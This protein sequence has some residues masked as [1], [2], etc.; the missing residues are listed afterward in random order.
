MITHHR[1]VSA[2]VLLTLAASSALARTRVA[3]PDFSSDD[4]SCRSMI[5]GAQ[6]AAALQAQMTDIADAEWVERAE[7]RHILSEVNLSSSALAAAD[8]IRAGRLLKADLIIQGQFMTVGKERQLCLEAI[9]LF[10]AEVMATRTIPC[11]GSIIDPVDVSPEWL[12]SAGAAARE[13]LAE[14]MK[15][16]NHLSKQKSIGGLFIRNLSPNSRLNFLNKEIL[17]RLENT[18][19]QN[20]DLRWLKFSRTSESLAEAQLS[21]MGLTSPDPAAWR[22]PADLFLWGSVEEQSGYTGPAEK[23]PF[24]ITLETWNGTDNLQKVTCKTTLADWPVDIQKAAQQLQE[25]ARNAR[26]GI[27]PGTRAALSQKLLN[28]GSSGPYGVALIELARFFSPDDAAIQKQ[29]LTLRSNLSPDNTRLYA[30]RLAQVQDLAA[31]IEQY[32]QRAPDGKDDPWAWRLF[33]NHLRAIFEIEQQRN[34]RS[35][36]PHDFNRD[37]QHKIDEQLAVLARKVV[38]KFSALR[39]R[40]PQNDA[41]RADYSLVRLFNG[42][43]A[44]EADTETK[45]QLIDA[46]WPWIAAYCRK[47]SGSSDPDMIAMRRNLVTVY[48]SAGQTERVRAMLAGEGAEAK[49]RVITVTVPPVT[50]ASRMP[51]APVPADR[52]SRPLP[53]SMPPEMQARIRELE[54]KKLGAGAVS[55]RVAEEPPG[56]VKGVPVIPITYEVYG[57]VNSNPST[58]SLSN[59]STVVEMPIRAA[60]AAWSEGSARG[61]HVPLAMINDELWIALRES[62]SGS[63]LVTAYKPARVQIFGPFYNDPVLRDITGMA[64]CD[65]KLFATSSTQGLVMLRDA[66]GSPRR[67]FGGAEGLATSCLDAIIADQQYVY[68]AG[69]DAAGQG[70]S[71]G[72]GRIIRYDPK[73]S[74][75]EDILSDLPRNE[76][77]WLRGNTLVFRGANGLTAIDLTTRAQYVLPDA[78]K[79]AGWTPRTPISA[80]TMK[81]VGLTPHGFWFLSGNQIMGLSED[82]QKMISTIPINDAHITACEIAPDGQHALIIANAWNTIGRDGVLAA[83]CAYLLVIDLNQ[84]KLLMQCRL[85][86]QPAGLLCAANRIWLAGGIHDPLIAINQDELKLPRQPGISAPPSATVEEKIAIAAFN[87]DTATLRALLAKNSSALTGFIPNGRYK[88]YECAFQTASFDTLK[89]LMGE[90]SSALTPPDNA[91]AWAATRNMPGLIARAAAGSLNLNERT[92]AGDEQPLMLAIACGNEEAVDA[93]IT[94]GVDIN[95]INRFGDSPL[96]LAAAY[97]PASLVEKILN[98][99]PELDARQRGG[100]TALHLAAMRNDPQI[101]KLL[102]DRGANPNLFSTPPSSPAQPMNALMLAI[103]NRNRDAVALLLTKGARANDTSPKGQSAMTLA[104]ERKNQE[105]IDLLQQNGGADAAVTPDT[106]RHALSVA[107]RN[108]DL[109]ELIRLLD[110]GANP[111]AANADGVY[112]I[113]EAGDHGSMEQIAELLKHGAKADRLVTPESSVARDLV[114]DSTCRRI[115]MALGQLAGVATTQFSVPELAASGRLPLAEALDAGDKASALAAINNHEIPYVP[116]D[117][118][119]FLHRAAARHMTD[120]IVPMLNNQTKDPDLRGPG[121]LTPLM[122]AAA[123]NDAEMVQLLLKLGA[124]IHLQNSDGKNAVELARMHGNADVLKILVDPRRAQDRAVVE[125]ASQHYPN[126]LKLLL[127]SGLPVN[128]ADI[129]GETPLMAAARARSTDCLALLLEQKADVNQKDAMGRTA[130]HWAILTPE[131]YARAEIVRMLVKAGADPDLADNNGTSARQYSAQKAYNDPPDLFKSQ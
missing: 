62:A 128:G 14:G 125:A 80:K 87:N 17:E 90:G 18:I 63:Q 40:N 26:P 64:E 112:P 115:A 95:K 55:V 32:P 52:A 71:M 5:A 47:E 22:A 89:I 13:V 38:A 83:S 108:R 84:N 92:Y 107:I 49:P 6:T 97:A 72:R 100:M 58:T 103:R 24:T 23:V 28:R 70:P 20:A 7:L 43:L 69:H 74:K 46:L 61:T 76:R 1:L 31:Y 121:D 51:G 109:A 129:N 41:F 114:N 3:L 127:T 54:Q 98:A 81:L 130:L 105:I 118:W 45:I 15:N 44:S 35:G 65:G 123:A 30:Y 21:I 34:T 131:P 116:K 120:L 110:S 4:N 29:V 42:I 86:G 75:F 122:V 36:L 33:A 119:P 85:P 78:L 56:P 102:L 117:Q 68:L 25:I 79:A 11:P 67:I 91:A 73:S 16:Q 111:N 94:A 124:Q 96:T 88:P 39:E 19:N 106:A 101:M 2:S 126:T 50:P 59:L 9:D 113:A 37:E 60:G 93:L 77:L 12:A 10:R 66:A 57:D 53:P 99:K 27:T 82:R 48:E 104:K 8:V